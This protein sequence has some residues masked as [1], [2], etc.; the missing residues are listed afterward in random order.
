MPLDS[1]EDRGFRL[2]EVDC[3]L[4][5]VT[6]IDNRLLITS[7]DVI[8]SWAVP[9]FGVKVDCVPGRLNQVFV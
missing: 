8:H 7:A 1:L 5:L 3:R 6:N 2:L 9:S 4:V